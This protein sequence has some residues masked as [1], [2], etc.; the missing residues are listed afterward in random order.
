MDVLA[1]SM[2][3]SDATWT[4]HANPWSVH[5]RFA[6]LPLLALAIWSRVWLGP[7]TLAPIALVVLWTFVNP[8][9]FPPPRD[10]GRWASRG[11]LGE[12]VL[13]ARRDALPAHHRRAARVL[14]AASALGV[15]PLAWGLWALDPFATLLGIV[16]TAGAK[17]WFV[18][19]MVWLHADLTGTTPGTPLTA[20]I[21]FDGDP[22]WH[23]RT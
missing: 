6:I 21:P 11:V 16:M 7:W 4:R 17:A 3:M 18:D 22:P 1:A 14:T 9:A 19:R 13:L 10:Y 2:R 8:R 12:R 5:T 20:P 15:V 23:P